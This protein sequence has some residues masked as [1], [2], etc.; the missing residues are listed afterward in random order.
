VLLKSPK[1]IP[2]GS[3]VD[4]SLFVVPQMKPV[5]S[6]GSVVRLDHENRVGVRF[7]RLS[8]QESMRLQEVLLPMIPAE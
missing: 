8:D 1:P 2:I 6:A 4:L 7:S 3:P 5:V